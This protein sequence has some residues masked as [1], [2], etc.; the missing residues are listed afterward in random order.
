MKLSRELH[1][2]L[3]GSCGSGLAF[4]DVAQLRFWKYVDGSDTRMTFA[5]QRGVI[6]KEG[7]ANHWKPGS[8]SES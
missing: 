1:I 7:H 3:K 5:L 4:V 6:G 8:C 2:S